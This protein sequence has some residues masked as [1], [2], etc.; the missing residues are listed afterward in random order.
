ME[1]FQKTIIL[2]PRSRG[3]HIITDEITGHFTELKAFKTGILH[4][5]IQHTSAS[6]TI[7]ENADIDV[8]RD[9]EDHFKRLI[10]E[11]SKLYGHTVEGLDDMTSH[12]KASILGNSLSIPITNGHLNL[13]IW[14]GIYLG[15]HRERA[16]GRKIVGTIIGN[17]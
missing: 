3:F 7:N 1:I 14:Q 16:E 11:D 6:I 8:R 10:P 2:H 12:L 4:I 5:F 9:F 17:K 13:G 15:E